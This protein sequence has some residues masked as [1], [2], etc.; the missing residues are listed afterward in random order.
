MT[1]TALAPSERHRVPT[2]IFKLYE[3]CDSSMSQLVALVRRV[4]A[5]LCRGS[6]PRIVKAM[7]DKTPEAASILEIM[8][9]GWAAWSFIALVM[10]NID[11]TLGYIV[12]FPIIFPLSL[13]DLPEEHFYGLIGMFSSFGISLAF[14]AG[15]IMNSL[16]KRRNKKILSS[17]Q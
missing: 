7:S 3:E 11:P 10:E 2:P 8:L 17:E 16:R 14:I 12:L 15:G 5:V 9:L 1:D 13:L 6:R 4:W